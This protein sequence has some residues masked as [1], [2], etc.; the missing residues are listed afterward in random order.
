MFPLNSRYIPN[1]EALDRNSPIFIAGHTGMVGSAIQ[2]LLEKEGFAQ[3]IVRT[4]KELDLRNESAT[5]AFFEET[6]PTNVVLAA[7]KVGGIMANANNPATY[8]MDNLSIQNN[9]MKA[10]LNQGVR[11]LLFFGSSCVYPKLAP[12]PIKEEYL[13]TGPLEV[14]NENYA[15]AKIA[16]LMQVKAIRK[17]YGLPW[18]SVMPT[19][20][21]GPNDNYDPEN[22]HV[23]A[24]FIKR[25][26]DAKVNNLP[27]VTCWGTGT[28]R[29]EFLHV[30]DLARACLLLLDTYDDDIAINVGVGEDISIKELAELVAKVVGYTGDIEW[31]TSKPDG[32]PRKLLDISQLKALKFTTG[33]ELEAGIQNSYTHFTLESQPG[34]F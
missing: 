1:M 34:M 13:L 24:A 14:T 9:V 10:A 5:Q 7:A 29:R 16:G 8:L 20:L 30:D 15:I 25:F 33:I 28:P 27:S 6:K 23:L 12:Q 11:R 32:T 31:D 17:Q 2:R 21:Y 3:I 4:S 19:N 18:I 22:S 26:H